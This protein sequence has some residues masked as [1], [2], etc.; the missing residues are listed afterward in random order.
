MLFRSVIS[1][2]GTAKQFYIHKLVGE[3]FVKNPKPNEYDVVLH[4]DE[5]TENNHKDNLKWGT[6]QQA[7]KI[8]KT[9]E[10]AKAA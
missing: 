5:N 3:V 4:I 2:G 7:C 1:Q 10:K 8:G 6:Q 9:G